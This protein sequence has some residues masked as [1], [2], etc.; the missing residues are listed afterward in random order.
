MN[1]AAVSAPSLREL[2]EDVSR[3]FQAGR[4]REANQKVEAALAEYPENVNFL[5][6]GG[7][8]K[9]N[10]GEVELAEKLLR[11][12]HA[13]RPEQADILHNLAVFLLATN[14]PQEA[15]P[16]YEQ[17]VQL[18]PNRAHI[19]SNFGHALRQSGQLGASLAAFER[20]EAL[21]PKQHDMTAV[22]A[23]VKRQMVLWDGT[24]L[25]V[26]KV[27][28]NLAPVFL[29]DP[30]LHLACARKGA[31]A[32]QPPATYDA[33]LPGEGR[34][35]IG[36]LSSDLHEHATSHLLAGLFA[37]HDRAK[38][39]VFVYSF[40]AESDAPVRSRM[41]QGTE[42]WVEC[43][44]M[45]APAIAERI[46]KDRLHILVDLKG[47]TRGSLPEVL[48]ARPAPVIMQWLG[49]PG[50]M[51]ADF[52]D[53]I[54]A[55]P[56][57]VPPEDGGFY[58]EKV[59]RLPHSYQINDAARPLL[60]AKTRADY[61]L[62]EK[63]LVLACFN[64]SYKI[65]PA[66]FGVWMRVMK[67]VPGS[68][69]WLFAMHKEAEANL[70]MEAEK[71][72]VDPVR[73]IFAQRA[74]Q[75]EHIARYWQVD[76]VVDTAPYGGHTTTSDALW[77]GTPVVALTGRSFAAKVS[78]SLLEAAGLPEYAAAS[79]AEYEALIRRLLSPEGERQ[80]Q[81][82]RTHLQ[83]KRESLPLFDTAAF[84]RHLEKGYA[85]AVQSARENKP[86]AD[87]TVTA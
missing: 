29:D 68:V 42:H 46:F 80:R 7:L 72:G 17:L 61:G 71:R 73:L 87:I 4:L 33:R 18:A 35:R 84:V 65:T 14:Q 45:P 24:E 51:G 54:I 48:A 41:K 67:D 63:G 56:V 27:T 19:W 20:A 52:V 62:P 78:T 5:H 26:E 81:R 22:V 28:A 21:D 77:A 86:P 74:P 79:L 75:A 44:G 57:V 1:K 66:V 53:Y 40:G 8:I 13:L 47:Y 2:F 30:A 70:K 60:S 16:Y 39:E 11:T 23:M 76:I 49:Y 55:D 36:Y 31:V 12:A 6:I 59:L 9:Q 50:S 25:P 43:R 34:I 37:A 58:T 10:L 3:L 83:T 82:I 85:E 32:I 38:F 69:L 15:V 64:Q